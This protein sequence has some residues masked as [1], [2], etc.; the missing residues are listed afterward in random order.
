MKSILIADAGSTKID[1]AYIS[2]EHDVCRFRTVGMNALMASRAE[3]AE[4]FLSLK[5]HIGNDAPDEVYYY[6][7]GCATEA[8]RSKTGSALSEALGVTDPFVDSDLAGAAHA[9]LGHDAGI[10]C[11][12]GTG[13]NSCLYDGRQI[14]MNVPSLGFILGDEGSGA[15]IGRRLASNAFKGLM[16]EPLRQKFIDT[17]GLSLAD[18]LDNVYCRPAPNRFLASFVHFVGDNIDDPYIAELVHDEFR[19]FLTR[20]VLQYPDAKSMPVSFTGSIA[21][22]FRDMLTDT[23]RDAGLSLGKIAAS[24]LEGLIAFHRN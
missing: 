7:A 1:W 22:V 13:S 12:L 11:I 10:A 20:N 5:H 17:Y 2:P 8:I 9:L 14:I 24:P 18:I 23:M 19:N 21:S 16:P 3:M 4:L 15:S 6:G